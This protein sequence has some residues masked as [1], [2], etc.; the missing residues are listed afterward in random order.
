MTPSYLLNIK[1]NFLINLH[2]P[3][4]NSKLLFTQQNLKKSNWLRLNRT[5]TFTKRANQKKK[6]THLQSNE[7]SDFNLMKMIRWK[8]KSKTL[9]STFSSLNRR[10]LRS[11]LKSE[12]SKSRHLNSILLWKFKFRKL[13]VSKKKSIIHSHKTS[14]TLS[15]KSPRSIKNFK[16]T[17]HRIFH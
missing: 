13:R 6:K 11:I 4:K 15:Q 10:W 3:P 8:A 7:L 5:S 12:K 14:L 1:N 16:L 17:F 9:K 2:L